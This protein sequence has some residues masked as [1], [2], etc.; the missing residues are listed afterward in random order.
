MITLN[1]TPVIPTIFPD[2]TSQVWK[3]PEEDLAQF[4]A[5]VEWRFENEGEFMHLAQ[6]AFLLMA[7][8]VAWELH[9]PYLPYARQDKEVTNTATFALCPF[10]AL[11]VVLQPRRVVLYDPHNVEPIQA[12]LG[13]HK[14]SVVVRNFEAEAKAAF[15]ECDAEV[16]CFPDSGAHAR[17]RDLAAGAAVACAYKA[18]DQ[19]TGAITGVALGAHG[20]HVDGRR[21]MIVDDICDGGATFIALAKLLRE[22]GAASVYLFVSHG[23]FS[24]GLKPLFEAGINRIFTPDGEKE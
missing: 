22:H 20:T 4:S 19:A 5:S 3:L 10:S 9:L 1:S 7:R 6:L 21:V 2:K 14:I 12:I 8:G 11:L 15:A 13:E 18:R 17:Y 16:W 23:I 24:R